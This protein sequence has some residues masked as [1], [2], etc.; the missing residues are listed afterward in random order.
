MNKNM[1]TEYR[2]TSSN[3]GNEVP[4]DKKSELSS[5]INFSMQDYSFFAFVK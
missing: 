1:L 2:E 5:S 3:K 4:Q